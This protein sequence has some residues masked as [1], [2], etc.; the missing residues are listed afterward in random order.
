MR[1]SACHSDMP[2]VAPRLS[3]QR[4]KGRATCAKFVCIKK[5][6]R[7]RDVEDYAGEVFLPPVYVRALLI[8]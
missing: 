6:V 2:D 5:S 8:S 3:L 7:K 1:R 4:G